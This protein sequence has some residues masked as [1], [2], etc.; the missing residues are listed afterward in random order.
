MKIQGLFLDPDPAGGGGAGNPFEPA[1]DVEPNLE[2][3]PD[4]NLEAAPDLEPDPNLEAAPAD[5]PPTP[6]PVA[7]ASPTQL[8][9]DMVADIARRASEGT[10]EG[11][12]KITP[13]ATP[14]ELTPE[15]FDRTFRVFRADE[16]FISRLDSAETPAAKAAVFN[17]FGQGVVRQALT[18]AQHIIADKEQQFRTMLAPLMQFRAQAEEHRL[19]ERLF[20]L[21]KDLSEYKPLVAEVKSRL[22]AQKARFPTE[23]AA[24]KAIADETRRVLK[25]LGV[26]PKPGQQPQPNP[27]VVTPTRKPAPLSRAGHGG[28]PAGGGAG[29]PASTAKTIFG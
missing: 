10:L 9:P 24:L 28:S 27:G 25:S 22:I 19:E 13:A 29:K 18:M 15:E 2:A 23:D 14:K 8:T 17:E 6:A 4:P 12:K 1:P 16:N 21:H 7:S 20:T 5:A 11:L 26:V 3:Q